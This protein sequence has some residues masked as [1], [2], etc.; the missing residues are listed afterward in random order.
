MHSLCIAA[1]M[2]QSAHLLSLDL[3]QESDR[4]KQAL[5][6]ERAE[7]PSTPGLKARRSAGQ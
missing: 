3:A 2:L 6:A 7:A 4:L 5:A 1:R